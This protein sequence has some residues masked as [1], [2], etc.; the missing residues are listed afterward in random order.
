V[1]R[2]LYLG[3]GTV[4]SRPS[5]R[6]ACTIPYAPGPGTLDAMSWAWLTGTP[7][8]LV[9]FIAAVIGIPASVVAMVQLVR[10]V[11]RKITRERPETA[12][13]KSSIDLDPVDAA[14][15]SAVLSR[16]REEW[17]SLLVPICKPRDANGRSTGPR[18]A[19]TGRWPP[20]H[21]SSSGLPARRP[22]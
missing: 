2:S 6:L 14:N 4:A 9:A 22:R 12:I 20:V 7:V 19:H 15:L 8:L 18:N 17:E 13:F 3:V 5:A 10:H 16:K 11:V 1:S 21:G